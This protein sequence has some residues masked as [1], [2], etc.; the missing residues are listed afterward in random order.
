MAPFRSW[1]ATIAACAGTRRVALEYIRRMASGGRWL[2]AFGPT[3]RAP[4]GMKPPVCFL[5]VKNW[6][7]MCEQQMKL[8]TPGAYS[9][10][11]PSTLEADS[12]TS[13]SPTGSTADPPLSTSRSQTSS[14]TTGALWE[15]QLMS[16]VNMCKTYLCS[17]KCRNDEFGI[18]WEYF[19]HRDYDHEHYHE[20]EHDCGN[21]HKHHA[22][23]CARLPSCRLTLSHDHFFSALGG[24]STKVI[25]VIAVGGSV[26]VAVVGGVGLAIGFFINKRCV[27][28]HFLVM[29]LPACK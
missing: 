17:V 4:K 2:L 19:L 10:T 12:T 6:Y 5:L 23:R 21:G 15:K 1:M 16:V 13:Q 27:R 9:T 7:Q 14:S 11:G 29:Q 18:H 26:A 24:L 28:V 3:S 8:K 22:F 25:I 20:H